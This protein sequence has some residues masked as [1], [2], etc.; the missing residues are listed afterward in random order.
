MVDVPAM[1][2]VMVIVDPGPN[3]PT[4]TETYNYLHDCF[5][6][7]FESW[8]HH[9]P[10]VFMVRSAL[11]SDEVLDWL[12]R[13]WPVPTTSHTRGPRTACVTSS[14]LVVDVTDRPFAGRYLDWTWLRSA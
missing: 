6:S 11:T 7:R 9:L 1:K 13:V 2:L 14:V 4:E 8:W 3:H 5:K 12:N 10:N